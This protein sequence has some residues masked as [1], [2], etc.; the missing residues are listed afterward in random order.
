MPD[1]GLRFYGWH[2]DKHYKLWCA[3][4][5]LIEYCLS[6]H[7]ISHYRKCGIDIRRNSNRSLSFFKRLPVLLKAFLDSPVITAYGD[8][9]L[10]AL[11]NVKIPEDYRE[12]KPLPSNPTR[13]PF[14]DLPSDIEEVI[15]ERYTTQHN[16]PTEK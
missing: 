4:N 3:T 10:H 6:Q 13:N 14:D 8:I 7:G 5:Q 15:L 16:K 11:Q 12:Y 9:K 1:G 2:E